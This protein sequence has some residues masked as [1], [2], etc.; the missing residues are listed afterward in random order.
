[1]TL[2]HGR[3]LKQDRNV[4]LQYKRRILLATSDFRTCLQQNLPAKRRKDE[5]GKNAVM[6][7]CDK[8]CISGI[9]KE[10]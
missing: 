8:G 5:S 2:R 1:M 9:Y 3:I 6:L 4:Q 7:L 10:L